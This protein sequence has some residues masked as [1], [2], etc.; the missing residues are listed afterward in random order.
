MNLPFDCIGL[1]NS[2]LPAQGFP[3]AL[4]TGFFSIG[5]GGMAGQRRKNVG[6]TK[7]PLA[8]SKTTSQIL[9]A[10]AFPLVMFPG[11]H[12][13]CKHQCTKLHICHVRSRSKKS[14]CIFYLDR[15]CT[16]EHR[17]INVQMRPSIKLK[18][19]IPVRAQVALHRLRGT[20]GSHVKGF[21]R[22]VLSLRLL[23]IARSDHSS[24]GK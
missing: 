15:N 23:L 17:F 7:S 13:T 5:T 20:I 22:P 14:S 6:W 1:S 4:A 12:F 24:N 9:L 10:W 3:L 18:Y 11:I 19:N 8:L 21:Q 2:E 16:S